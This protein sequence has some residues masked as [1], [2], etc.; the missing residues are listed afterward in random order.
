M[1]QHPSLFGQWVIRYWHPREIVTIYSLPLLIGAVSLASL[2]VFAG[3]W[4]ARAHALASERVSFVNSVSHELRTPLTNILLSVDILETEVTTEAAKQRFNHIQEESHRLARIV[5]NVLS[6]AQIE[7]G[8]LSVGAKKTVSLQTLLSSCIQQFDLPFSRK[9][10]TCDLSTPQKS[11]VT[12]EADS[13]AQI[14]LNLLSNIEKYAGEGTTAWIKSEITDHLLIQIGDDGIGIPNSA[15]QRIF[16]A[17]ERIDHK[18]TTG[19][20]GTGLGLT[21]SR[22]L[23]R[24]LDG[25]LV[26]EKSEKGTVFRLELPLHTST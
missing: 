4:I 26:L 15:R 1:T 24:N 14:I 10:I 13:L 8:K 6:F 12:V 9:R 25:D 23:A 16:S 22:E 17:F 5:E 20:S 3:W 11:T 7:N 18:A 2:I 19:T 21:I